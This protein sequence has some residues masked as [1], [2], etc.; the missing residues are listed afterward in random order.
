M[1]LSIVQA[2]W[3][4]QEIDSLSILKK[5][6]LD[7]VQIPKNE[8]NELKNL[9]SQILNDPAQSELLRLQNGDLKFDFDID[10]KRG[11]I[12]RVG[13][14]RAGRSIAPF[15]DL[16]A[17]KSTP[18]KIYQQIKKIQ[19]IAAIETLGR[20]L[21]LAPSEREILHNRV[22]KLEQ[23]E[24]ELY[25]KDV[26]DPM[27]RTFE[28][29]NTVVDTFAAARNMLRAILSAP[30]SAQTAATLTM[31]AGASQLLGGALAILSGGTMFAKGIGEGK[32]SF[33]REDYEGLVSN[34]L[35]AGIGASYF[36]VGIGFLFDSLNTLINGATQMWAGA[37]PL[38]LHAV[39]AMSI[40]QAGHASIG[41]IGSKDFELDLKEKLAPEREPNE[42]KRLKGALKW[43]EAQVSLSDF[44]IFEIE[45]KAS[46]LDDATKKIAEKLEGKWDRFERRTDEG[47]SALVRE[48]LK[49]VLLRLDENDENGVKDAKSLLQEVEKA[50]Y[51]KQIACTISLVI[52]IISFVGAI[53]TIA[54][55]G[56]GAIV[57]ILFVLGSLLWLTI[58]NSKINCLVSDVFW[59]QKQLSSSAQRL[60]RQKVLDDLVNKSLPPLPAPREQRGASHQSLQYSIG[61]C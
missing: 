53:L 13:A 29:I 19:E 36:S 55:L 57:P 31:I 50:N 42:S 51:K 33:A 56:P 32:K 30:L 7:S 25:F 39:I 35:F 16:I 4:V 38:V 44:E 52:A 48:K 9:F 24:R 46:S 10:E 41:L 43:I 2:P 49:G 27:V 20:K 23:R 22:S 1:A 58:D 59:E 54:S 40:I 5:I 18:A 17:G 3:V 61:E 34:V 45:F 12:L 6:G 21:Q 28:K 26:V 14:E 60:A 11:F 8:K 47:C 37:G 15:A